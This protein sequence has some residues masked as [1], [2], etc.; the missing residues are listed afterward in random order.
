MSAK[1]WR[2]CPFCNRDERV[3]GAWVD[4]KNPCYMPHRNLILKRRNGQPEMHAICMIME[5]K[6]F[7]LNKE[8]N[9]KKRGMIGDNQKVEK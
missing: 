7:F 3:G 2:V 9:L 5:K 4:R 8:G 1:K 6:G